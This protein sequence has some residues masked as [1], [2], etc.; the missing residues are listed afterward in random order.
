MNP[1]YTLPKTPRKLLSMLDQ[2]ALPLLLDAF[3]ELDEDG[4][5]PGRTVVGSR[6]ADVSS[7]PADHINIRILQSMISGIPLIMSLKWPQ[8]QSLGYLCLGGLL[9]TKF[10]VHWARN[11]RPL[12][13]FPLSWGS[14]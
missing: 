13:S 8:N 4:S 7:G 10:L 6:T 14:K 2:G 11:M 9:G 12:A 3:E 5:A 1:I